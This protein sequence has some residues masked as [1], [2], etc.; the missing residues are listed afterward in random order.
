MKIIL[1]LAVLA[2]TATAALADTMPAGVKAGYD[3]LNRSIAKMDSK[4]FEGYF[5]AGFVNVDPKGASTPREDFL[6]SIRPLFTAN[7][8][9]TMTEKFTGVKVKGDQADVNFDMHLTLRGKGGT[10][11][12]HEV[13][14]DSWKKTGGKWLLIKTVDTVLDM[15]V[16]SAGKN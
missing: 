6:K 10:T 4:A 2:F 15:K 7:K 12:I 9:G 1:T 11:T 3:G 13:G 14:V 16:P 8:S 5:A